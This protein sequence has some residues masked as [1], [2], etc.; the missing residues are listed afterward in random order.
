MVRKSSPVIWMHIFSRTSLTVSTSHALAWHTTSRSLGLRNSERSQKVC[1]SGSHPSE[2]KK[3]S[4]YF[5]IC[6]QSVLRF[7]SSAVKPS[8]VLGLEEQRTLP[9]GL[10]QRIES[11]RDE[12]VLSVLPHLLPVRV[13]PLQQPVPI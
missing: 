13:A 10:R 2:T 11:Q 12:E 1:G 5:T 8:S 3:F 6:F 7:L 4:P 9:E